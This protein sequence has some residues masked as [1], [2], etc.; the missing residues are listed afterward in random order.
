M[1]LI[2][3]PQ[4]NGAAARRKILQASVSC[5]CSEAGFDSVQEIA[6]ETICEM[7]QS[8]K[9]VFDT[10]ESIFSKILVGH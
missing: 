9:C 10:D 3:E 8:C 4:I 7:M 1:A 5:L 2:P 6:L